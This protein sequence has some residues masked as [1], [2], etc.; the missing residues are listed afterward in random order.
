MDIHTLGKWLMFFY[1]YCL[2]GW[3]IES[4]I[5]SFKEK[6]LVNRGFMKGPLLPIYGSG[7]V[8][9]LF[10]CLPFKQNI[11]SVYLVGMISA[12]ILEYITGYIME[13][14]LNMRYWDYSNEKFN[15]KGKICLTSSLFWGFLSVFMTFVIHT[16]IEEIVNK[17]D[18]LTPIITTISI[19]FLIDFIFS[20]INVLN[21]NKILRFL[22]LKKIEMDNLIVQIKEDALSL[23]LKNNLTKRFIALKCD[24]ENKIKNMSFF[25]KQI[26]KSYPKATSKKFND[27]IK[28]IKNKLSS[29]LRKFKK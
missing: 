13:L 14:T 5:V 21:L 22:S 25:H 19:Y 12:T 18:N 23:E 2:F 10:F 26:I 3:I 29:Q 6:R 4:S 28:D 1:I 8:I 17:I 7:A 20:L 9:V 24:Y 11:L 27:S 16:P 15:Y